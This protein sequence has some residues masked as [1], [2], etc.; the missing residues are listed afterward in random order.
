MRD[1]C[2][3]LKSRTTEPFG[4]CQNLANEKEQELKDAAKDLVSRC[5]PEGIILGAEAENK[6]YSIDMIEDICKLAEDQDCL[7]IIRQVEAR[8]EEGV[9]SEKLKMR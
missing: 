5:P 8:V 6:P 3:E 9:K 7:D 2:Q 4:W 1:A